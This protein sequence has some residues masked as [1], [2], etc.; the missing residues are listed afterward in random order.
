M[1]EKYE[2]FFNKT[3]QSINIFFKKSQISLTHGYIWLANKL[4]GKSK[5]YIDRNML[6]IF[7]NSDI[8]NKEQ[9]TLVTSK[10]RELNYLIF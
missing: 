3:F 7:D 1:Q 8:G 4:P 6:H 10:V 5:K 2:D 9:K